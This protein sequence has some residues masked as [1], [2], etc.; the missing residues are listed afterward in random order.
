MIC[1]FVYILMAVLTASAILAVESKEYGRKNAIEGV[2]IDI[3]LGFLWPIF[4]PIWAL[5][6]LVV[7]LGRLMEKLL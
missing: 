4:L 3:I 1:L 2:A 6:K 5:Y 7:I